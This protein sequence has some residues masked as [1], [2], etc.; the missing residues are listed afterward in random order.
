MEFGFDHVHIV[1]GDPEEMTQFFE[2]VFGADRISYDPDF[3]GAPSASLQL[4]DMH[5]FVRSRIS[6]FDVADDLPRFEGWRSP[7]D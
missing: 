6:W 3:K 2:R 4:G 1:C 5:I 7:A